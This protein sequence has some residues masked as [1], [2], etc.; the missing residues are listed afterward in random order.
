M[1]KTLLFF[2]LCIATLQVS[3]KKVS[4]RQ[5]LEKVRELEKKA[6]E[7]R[8]QAGIGRQEVDKELLRELGASYERFADAYPDAPE[9]P[10]FLFRAGE[11]YSNE[12]Q[13]YNKAIEV[14]DR[15]YRNYPDHETAAN[16][17]FFIGYLYNNSV[18]DLVKAE[19]YYKEFLEA[20][21]KHNMAPHA[22]FE[23]K[24]LGMSVEEV[25]DQLL[26]GNDSTGVSDSATVPVP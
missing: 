15:N 4:S 24:S 5:D 9:T 23:L 26:Q 18:R 21:P 3:C 17:L 8:E 12:L 6:D 10:E 1:N 22:E 11:V 2:F 13:D 20:Y 16:A 7:S 19:Q 25:F 14:F